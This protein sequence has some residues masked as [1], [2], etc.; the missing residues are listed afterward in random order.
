MLFFKRVLFS[1]FII[2]CCENSMCS[3][4]RDKFY[5]IFLWGSRFWSGGIVGCLLVVAICDDLAVYIFIRM[6]KNGH[7]FELCSVVNFT[8]GCRFCCRL[9]NSLISPHGHFQNMKQSSK[10][11]FHY[12]VN[13]SFMSLPYFLHIISYRLSSKYARVRVAYVGAILVPL[14][15]PSV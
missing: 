3:S 1:V 7:S 13:S 10:Y 9:C 5:T 12:L 15:V 8:L 14:A 4:I 2:D 6:S 11:L